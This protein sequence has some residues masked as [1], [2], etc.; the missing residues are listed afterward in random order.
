V[1]QADELLPGQA[2]R[3]GGSSKAEEA[4]TGESA[5]EAAEAEQTA[6]SQ[7]TRPKQLGPEQI[8]PLEDKDF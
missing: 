5:P 3:I 1:V 7:T 4:A 2:L 6:S 8:I